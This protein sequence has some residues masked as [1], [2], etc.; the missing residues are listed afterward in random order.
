MSLSVLILTL[1][2]AEN[3]RN[4][5]ESVAWCD[6]TV[7]LDS[8]SEDGTGEVA[9]ESGAR[10]VQREFDDFAGQ[11]NFGIDHIPF[12]HE[13][14]FHLDA[15]ERFSP[16]LADECRKVIADDRCSGFLVPSKMVLHGR[17][18]KHAADY[19][20]YQ[21]RLMKLGEVRFV[22][23]GHGQ[24]ECSDR[25]GLGKLSAPYLH[26]SFSK[27]LDDWFERHNR[28]STMEAEACLKELEG[29][30]LD[31]GGLLSG[32]PIVKRR[33]L[34]RLSMRLPFRPWLKFIYMYSLGMGFLDGGPGLTYCVL[35]AIYEYM[36]SLKVRDLRKNR[37]E[38]RRQCIS[39]SSTDPT[40]LTRKLRGSS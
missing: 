3:L 24:R 5:L 22:Q 18:L 38:V 1:N 9:R 4:C 16:E 19:P 27:G 35:Q 15:D 23:H 31:W 29:T 37:Q 25:R 11:R 39:S 2:E 36:I 17:W 34:K 40:I 8:Y 26:Y 33:A 21:M 6:D 10:F 13:W 28:Y 12:K 7:V 20:V 14:V 30:G 32:D